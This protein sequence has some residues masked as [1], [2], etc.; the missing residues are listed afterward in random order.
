MP[1]SVKITLFWHC[2]SQETRGSKATVTVGLLRRYVAIVGTSSFEKC[3]HCHSPTFPTSFQLFL[4][5]DR[6]AVTHRIREGVER[7]K[8]AFLHPAE[9]TF[10]AR[11]QKEKTKEPSNP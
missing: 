1:G 9:A 7:L 4:L 6:D 8:G 3:R 2:Q 5:N 11:P 10:K